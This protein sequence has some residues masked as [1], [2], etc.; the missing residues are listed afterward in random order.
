MGLARGPDA[1]DRSAQV[2]LPG[3]ESFPRQDSP[4][5]ASVQKEDGNRDEGR[6]PASHEKSGGDEVGDQAVDQS[7]GANVDDGNSVNRRAAQPA[8]DPGPD[9]A[10]QPDIEERNFWAITE[11]PEQQRQKHEQG[12]GIGPEM[13]RAAMQEGAEDNANQPVNFAGRNSELVERIV[14]FRS[15]NDG[16]DPDDDD[17]NDESGSDQQRPTEGRGLGWEG[18]RR[19][20][21]NACTCGASGQCPWLS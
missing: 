1:G 4:E 16:C 20:S 8:D 9:A 3:N 7:A 12:N 17:G 21:W 14:I 13:A 11:I 5:D 18:R 6:A 15:H 19:H 10:A 2:R